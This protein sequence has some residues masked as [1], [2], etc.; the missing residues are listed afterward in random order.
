MLHWMAL[1]LCVCCLVTRQNGETQWFVEV[2][3]SIRHCSFKARDVL[4]SREGVDWKL[5]GCLIGGEQ[6]SENGTAMIVPL[7][8]VGKDKNGAE[9]DRM[10]L[11]SEKTFIFAQYRMKNGCW[12]LAWVPMEQLSRLRWSRVVVEVYRDAKN[13]CRLIPTIQFNDRRFQCCVAYAWHVVDWLGRIRRCSLKEYDYFDVG[14]CA[15]VM[16]KLK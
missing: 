13:R 2:S 4:W 3:G 8:W 11:L 14:Q 10:G 6:L 16:S 12:A 7:L 15:D 5:N 1:T 9:I